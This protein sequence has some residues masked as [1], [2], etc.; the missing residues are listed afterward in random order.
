MDNDICKCP[1]CG[2]ENVAVSMERIRPKYGA[3]YV[4]AY[5]AAL[6]LVLWQGFEC[7]GRPYTT[8]SAYNVAVAL[9]VAAVIAVI[10]LTVVFVRS[11]RARPCRVQ[12]C[13]RCGHAVA[14][15]KPVRGSR[16]WRVD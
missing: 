9:A 11:R 15:E 16:G 10:V 3:G 14:I 12:R 7:L 4:V 5:V 6:V 8:Q 1:N 2:A 13:P